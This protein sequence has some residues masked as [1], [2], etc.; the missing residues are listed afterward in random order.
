MNRQII[1]NVSRRVCQISA[2]SRRRFS[3]H[4]PMFP[5]RAMPVTPEPIVN[6]GSA[7]AADTDFLSRHGGK[8]ALIA[9]SATIGL[10]YTYVESNNIRSRLEEEITKESAIE[11]YEINDLRSINSMSSEIFDALVDEWYKSHR[12][13]SCTYL[14][15]VNFVKQFLAARGLRLC[16]GHILERVILTRYHLSC[17][18]SS[19]D[20]NENSEHIALQKFPSHRFDVG[21]LLAALNMVVSEGA[22]SRSASMFRLAR[23]WDAKTHSS[24]INKSEDGS[25]S[26]AQDDVCSFEAATAVVNYLCDT[27]QVLYLVITTVYLL[28]TYALFFLFFT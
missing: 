24:S 16:G 21:Y 27:W 20:S 18:I 10:I 12:D 11:P 14:E 8:V 4:S 9:I 7:A 13:E 3:L 6:A 26:P 1:S 19:D 5:Q 17:S 2:T 23:Y 28:N 25:I 15:F 22:P